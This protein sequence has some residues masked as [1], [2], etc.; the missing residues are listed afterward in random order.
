MFF[1]GGQIAGMISPRCNNSHRQM[2]AE[3]FPELQFDAA[4]M[5]GE[6][7][8]LFLINSLIQFNRTQRI[9]G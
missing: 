5:K 9:L 2:I 3:A 1:W 4:W 8:F 6:S 7:S